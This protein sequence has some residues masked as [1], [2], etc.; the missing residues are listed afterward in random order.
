MTEINEENKPRL[1]KCGCGEEVI[2]K[3]EFCQGH[4]HKLRKKAEPGGTETVKEEPKQYLN[5]QDVQSFERTNNMTAWFDDGKGNKISK[6]P[7]LIG[8]LVNVEKNE[9]IPTLLMLTANGTFIPPFLMTGFMGMLEEKVI[10][11]LPVE[12]QPKKKGILGMFKKQ[13]KSK[14][15]PDKPKG[16]SRETEVL[17]KQLNDVTT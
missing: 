9:S 6:V 15:E 2:G 14:V 10:L 12:E 17:L 16:V 13:A 1:C 11:P 4:A 5:I 3:G 7:D 8:L